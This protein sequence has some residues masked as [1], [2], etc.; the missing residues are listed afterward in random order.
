MAH[1]ARPPSGRET[2]PCPC[3]IIVI[4]NIITTMIT[5]TASSSRSI[6]IIIIIALHVAGVLDPNHVAGLARRVDVACTVQLHL[7]YYHYYYHSHYYYH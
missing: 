5:I 4:T 7:L 6:I 2:L 1:V 3:L